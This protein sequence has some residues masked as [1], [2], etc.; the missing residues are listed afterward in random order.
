VCTG[1]VCRSP[2]AEFL[3][4]H[5]FAERLR[6]EDAARFSVASAG[7]RAAVGA[8]MD[9]A[10][11]AELPRWGVPGT[12]ADD[13]VARQLDQPTAAAADLVLTADRAHRAH[14]V[15]LRSVA[16]RTTFCLREF[17]RLL[18]SVTLD[19]AERDPVRRARLAVA[20]TS[21]ARG[22]V[23]PVSP[24][25]DAVPDPVGLPREAHFLSCALIG[26]ALRTSLRVLE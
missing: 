21:L 3:T 15:G 23:P 20:A 24:A 19:P 4:R 25:D 11:R 26:T 5:L 7:I 8:R 10:T 2:F 22:S 6:P 13:H 14:V 16:L 17:S 12:A 18:A 1:N 9:S